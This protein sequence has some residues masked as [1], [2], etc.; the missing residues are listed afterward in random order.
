MKN[1]Y[2]NI[3]LRDFENLTDTSIYERVDKTCDY[4]DFLASKDMLNYRIP[5]LSGC[6]PVVELGQT[7]HIKKGEYVSF[8][9]N[10]YLGF[11]QHPKIKETAWQ[12]ITKFGSGAGAS[13][14]IGGYYD[15][16][17]Q[18][19]NK[20]ASFFSRPSG[21]SIIYTTGYTANSA[22]LLSLLSPQ[23]IAIVDM[24]VHTSVYEGIRTTNTKRFLHNDVSSLE[25]ILQT[26][27]GKYVNRV[28]IVDGVYS[29]DG[30]IAPLDKISELCRH[31]NALLAVDDA[32]GIGVIGKTGR[33]A[34]EMF[35]LM[36]KVDILTG[37]FS[38]TFAYIGGYVIATPKIIRYLHFQSR[39]YAFSASAPPSILTVGKAIDLIDQ[40]P[41]WQKKLWENIDYYKKGL[42]T[43]GL[44]VGTTASAI[45]P[46]KIGDRGKT[47]EL[48]KIL[49]ENG[50]YANPIT[51]PAVSLKDARIRMSI[52]ATHT[53]ENLDKAL[54]V[55]ED[56]NKKLKLRGTITSK[57]AK[58]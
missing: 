15:F 12:A 9:S 3:S 52:I 50:I 51:Y 30:D 16:H 8:V 58:T 13:P 48:A 46:V 2:A 43:I 22:T 31:Y 49:L 21:S 14:L 20:I 29:Q 24:A 56:A 25:R 4:L 26:T 5:A 19:E 33:G 35:N 40:E 6:G 45:V 23:D 54:N 34:L 44:D 53:R 1:N 7:G 11:T 10:D 28:V 38:K 47:L 57:N 36:D 32:H 39:Q 27:K 37:T 55:F 17:R 41:Q 42:Q 18:I